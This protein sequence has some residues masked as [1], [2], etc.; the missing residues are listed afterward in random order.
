MAK[1]PIPKPPKHLR[2]STKAWW[3][4]V[5]SDFY[6]EQHHLK[7][8]TLACEAFDRCEEAREAIAEHGTTYVDIGQP[9]ARPEIAIERDSRIAFSRLLRELAL[10]VDEPKDS[11][12]PTIHGNAGLRIG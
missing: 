2:T 11:R 1:Q 6:L 8:L 7:L 12:P 9:R 3:K 10:D 5:V 4:S